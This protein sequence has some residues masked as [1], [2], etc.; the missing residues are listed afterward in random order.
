LTPV[1]S[2]AVNA[3][4]F[5]SLRARAQWVIVPILAVATVVISSLWDS[6]PKQWLAIW[7]VALVLHSTGRWRLIEWLTKKEWPYEAKLNLLAGTHAISGLLHAAPL[8]AFSSMG[9]YPQALITVLLIGMAMANVALTSG[10]TVIAWSYQI[11]TIGGAALC[12]M[13]SPPEGLPTTASIGL[14]IAMF[15][16]MI[17]LGLHARATLLGLWRSMMGREELVRLNDEMRTALEKAESANRAKTR[18]LASASHDLRQPLH[19]L[20]MFSAALQLRPLDDKSADIARNIGT[21]IQDLT[22]EL[23][24]LLD[25]SKLDAGIVQV[26]NSVVNLNQ[27]LQNVRTIYTPIALE[28]H[29]HLNVIANALITVQTDRALLERIVRNLVDNAL[30]YSQAGTVLIEAQLDANQ[31]FAL[32]TVSDQGIGIS[33][34]EQTHIFDEFY[35][36]NNPERNRSKGLGLGL[37]IVKRLVNLLGLELSFQSKLGQGSVFTIKIPASFRGV[38]KSSSVVKP[39]WTQLRG[40]RVLVLDDE[41]TVRQSMQALLSETGCNVATAAHTDEALALTESFQPAL[42]LA[43][44]RL[45]GPLDGIQSIVSARKILPG[46]PAILISGD[47]EP[48]QL[49]AARKANITLLHKPVAFETLAA[50]ISNLLTNTRTQ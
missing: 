43:D 22:S 50:T 8:I 7:G 19:T 3:E 23:D 21:S 46:L 27:L 49:T 32:L 48:E 12:W 1:K 2:E 44:L 29:L 15:M 6:Q 34:A 11:P 36:V 10:H 4:I 26:N 16:L 37:A 14:G 41:P 28:R 31:A 39:Q 35:Q 30:K 25:I 13:L 45:Q 17:I 9:I 47:T 24:S 33:E 5:D 40:L 38:E 20:A 18:F 42:L